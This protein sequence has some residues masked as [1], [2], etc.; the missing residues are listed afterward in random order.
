MSFELRDFIQE[1]MTK[2]VWDLTSKSN[3]QCGMFMFDREIA[4]V[5]F[6]DKIGAVKWELE[7]S[8]IGRSHRE[9]FYLAG[10]YEV[11]FT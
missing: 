11:F 2:R 6:D 4:F 8:C 9:F 7:L 10:R 3:D 5:T 1:T